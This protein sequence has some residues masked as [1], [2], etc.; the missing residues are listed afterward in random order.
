MR[1]PQIEF[2]PTQVREEMG[3]AAYRETPIV[4]QMGTR[5]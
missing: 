2:N 5:S 4:I 3:L 1:T